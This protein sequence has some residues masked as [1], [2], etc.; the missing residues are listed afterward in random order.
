MPK[1]KGG[2]LGFQPG[3]QDQPAETTGIIIK[4]ISRTIDY[5]FDA[6]GKGGDV[7]DGVRK[8]I[9]DDMGVTFTQKG[10]PTTGGGSSKKKTSTSTKKK[11]S[12]TK[13]KTQ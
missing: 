1:Q 3:R 11:Q 6:L 9:S 7:I 8:I 12:I 2:M 5:M 13:K 10:T 4:N